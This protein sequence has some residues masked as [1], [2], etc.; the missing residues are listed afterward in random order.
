MNRFVPALLLMCLPIFLTGPI[1][2][3]A[4]SA[5]TGELRP[6]VVVEHVAKNSEGEKAGLRE[7]D[8]LLVW[9]HSNFEGEIKSPSALYDLEA[10][11]KIQ[12]AL[13]LRGLRNG[14]ER[15]WTLATGAWGIRGRPNFSEELLFLYREGQAAAKA[16][17][18][19]E[20]AA[21]FRAAAAQISR[22]Q[23]HLRWVAQWLLLQA[24]D[25]LA[26][27]QK[28]QE[29]NALYREVFQPGDISSRGSTYLLWYWADSFPD[30]NQTGDGLDFARTLN[31]MGLAARAR[32]DYDKAEEL[33]QRALA[34]EQEQAPD[35][36]DIANC[37][38]NLG[39]LANL[40]GD[41]AKAQDYHRRALAIE[42]K[43]V[44]NS[45]DV[46][47][48]LTCLG[49]ILG[50]RRNREQGDDYL[51]QALEIEQK[52]APGGLDITVE[53]LT[54]LGRH[55]WRRDD[56]VAA[57][58]L[59]QQA[60]AIQEKLDPDSLA[61][62]NNL[63]T[64]GLV[65]MDQGD[66]IAAEH[67]HRQALAIRQKK[68]RGGLGVA[69]S[70]TSLGLLARERGD[71]TKGEQY[72]RQALAIQKEGLG[73]D[74]FLAG[75]LTNLG[76]VLMDRN[77]LDQADKCF[78]EALRIYEKL[79]AGSLDV[80]GRLN[81]LGTVALARGDLV[82]AQN[83]QQQALQI[84]EKLAPDG[85]DTAWSLNN[86]GNVFAARHDLAGAEQY[87]RKALA[88]R[89]KL[90]PGGKFLAQTL[91]HLADVL[92]QKGD[93]GEAEE[94]YQRALA[95]EE[96][97]AP[98]SMD[99]AESLAGLASIMHRR[100]QMNQAAE[101]FER[102]LH[103]LEAQTDHL[104]G[105]ADVRSGFRASALAFYNDYIQLLVERNQFEQALNV[106]ERS[107]AR[108]MLETLSAAHVDIRKGVSPKLL[109]KERTR[110]AEMESKTN[111]RVQVLAGKHTQE[112]AASIDKEI[113][114]LR[115]QY[116]D[117]E[118]E[119]RVS[120][121]AYAALTHPTPL[122][123]R[124]IQQQ[125][126]DPGSLLL[127]YVLG[128]ERSYVFAVSSSAL[129][130]YELPKKADIEAAARPVHDMLAARSHVPKGESAA[131]RAL[132]LQ[133]AD[134]RY[135]EAVEK[136]S[137]MI[138]GPVAPL[139]QGKRLLIVRDGILEYV[140]FAA[141]P[142]PTDDARSTPLIVD[143]E[144]VSLPSAS[145]LQVLR[146][147]EAGRTKAEKAI[148]VLAD[149]VFQANDARIKNPGTTQAEPADSDLLRSAGEVG[150]LDGQFNF[151]RLLF[152]RKEA[153]AILRE[154]PQGGA[155][156]A[157]D[158][159]ASLD[160]VTGAKLS[161]YRI[162]H[163]ATHGLLNSLHPE[164]SGLVLSLVDEQGRAR[165]GFLS[166]ETIYNMTLPVDLVVLSA[167]E[168][169]LGKEIQGEGLLGITRGF[170]YA[171]A[172]RVVAS[173]WNV[174]DAATAQLMAKFYNGIFKDHLQPAAA[175]RRAQ[176]EMWKHSRWNLPY[177]WAGFVIQGEW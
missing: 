117:V 46:A 63:A 31:L 94:Y 107:R 121:P 127:E 75:L 38:N 41:S 160:T 72:L 86:L 34:I 25:T 102:A 157:L 163:F 97:L 154:A 2:A 98:D 47:A 143:H 161:Q 84:Q 51:R 68:A 36:L 139:L 6:G 145:V 165:P 66:L 49:L 172:S 13:R 64:L 19:S 103:S 44:P 96:K 85:L 15:K 133:N 116:Q 138:L 9:N 134:A 24:A 132:R 71:L 109:E 167:C 142:S 60:I 159:K 20:A 55:A 35:G 40:R 65:E 43:L 14:E 87:Y 135:P 69:K 17:N 22:D 37:L 11:W 89:E 82:Q 33:Y 62:A 176:V 175:L 122:S 27:A 140:P 169:G 5:N 110:Q 137:R 150:A 104:G 77:D 101:F 83:Y 88:V 162:V 23:L 173:L 119:I 91:N 93:S 81:N 79:D 164:L 92:Y 174:N 73:T 57:K 158:F 108:S 4:V 126:L 123:A 61:L 56:D 166:L 99:E 114:E 58:Q 168:T 30:R 54:T 70:L 136:L 80:A 59:M 171:G 148:A 144:I 76:T 28:L 130:V 39:V 1:S 16:G 100:G 29:A 125:V 74:S 113:K 112:Q 155:L 147:Q 149:P 131:Q 50:D 106:L 90:A 32:G 95:I 48:T 170:M 42:Q 146:Q 120:S 115:H 7:A 151:P 105:S 8:V 177:Y 118:D 111:I 3:Q 128:E 141:L 67:Y 10:E 152:S 26:D 12:G 53:A 21:R 156:K 129:A 78:A 153:N 18:P 52:L 45:L 124:Q